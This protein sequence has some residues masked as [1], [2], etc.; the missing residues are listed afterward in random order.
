L[1]IARAIAAVFFVV[2]SATAPKSH[3]RQHRKWRR[4]GFD[5]FGRKIDGKR[6]YVRGR[7]RGRG[8][9]RKV[10]AE[11]PRDGGA[12]GV[13]EMRSSVFEELA[14]RDLE[15][16][17]HAHALRKSRRDGAHGLV[18]ERLH[19]THRIPAGCIAGRADHRQKVDFAHVRVVRERRSHRAREPSLPLC[20]SRVLPVHGGQENAIRVARVLRA[21]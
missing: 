10:L 6:L 16:R 1:A 15:F 8:L 4:H 18:Y 9:V 11:F 19:D 20:G 12:P 21:G 2:P 17:A 3:E 14:A 13:R 7:N 5:R